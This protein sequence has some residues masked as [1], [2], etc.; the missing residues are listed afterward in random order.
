VTVAIGPRSPA[1]G[2]SQPSPY[3]ALRPS[4]R[5]RTQAQVDGF[6]DKLRD[7]SVGLSEGAAIGKS[8]NA[9]ASRQTYRSTD[10]PRQQRRHFVLPPLGDRQL[11][12]ADRIACPPLP[13]SVG[14]TLL[15]LQ[16]YVLTRSQSAS[17]LPTASHALPREQASV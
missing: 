1:G 13:Q 14:P 3:R 6:D 10:S 8:Q 7:L 9:C 12:K 5:T 17:W 4:A 16:R 15:H 2:S 11:P